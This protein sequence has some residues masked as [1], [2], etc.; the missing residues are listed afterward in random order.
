[1]GMNEAKHNGSC[2]ADLCYR[3]GESYRKIGSLIY[4]RSHD[5]EVRLDLIPTKAWSNN[6]EYF[7]GNFISS[8]K[9]EDAPFVDGD[10]VA[11]T[12]VRG[13]HVKVGHIHTRDN[14]TGEAQ[15]YMTLFGI[16]I[17]AWRKIIESTITTGK[18]R[19]LYLKVKLEDK[20]TS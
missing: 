5:A 12:D 8:A 4:F 9:V 18:K 17:T 13:E 3:D 2:I 19:A 15:Y 14:E 16:P 1:M 6:E 10:I 11:T 20:E 7:I